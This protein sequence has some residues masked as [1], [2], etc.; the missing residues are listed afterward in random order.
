MAKIK[1]GRGE[2][3]LADM[4]PPL[5]GAIYPFLELIIATALSW[6]L[7]GW[8]DAAAVDAGI[9]NAVVGIWFLIVIW[10]FFWPLIRQQRQ[11]FVVTNKRV[12]YLPGGRGRTESIPLMQIRNVRRRRGGIDIGI[13]GYGEP[14]HFPNVGRARRVEALIVEQLR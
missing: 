4:A 9:R 1:L 2:V 5:R 14:V 6:M 13:L 12:M 11:R 10:R 3:V 7:I 8:M